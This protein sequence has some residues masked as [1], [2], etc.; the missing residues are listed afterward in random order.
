MCVCI[1]SFVVD[2]NSERD[3]QERTRRQAQRQKRKYIDGLTEKRQKEC[4][5]AQTQKEVNEEK[6]YGKGSVIRVKKISGQSV[7]VN[8]DPWKRQRK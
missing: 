6:E 2:R 8:S 1:C 4:R 3:G 7:N 5:D